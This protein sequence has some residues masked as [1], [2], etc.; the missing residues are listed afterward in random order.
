MLYAANGIPLLGFGT[1]PLSGD[2]AERCILMAIEVGYR[3]FD[4]AQMYG[5]ENRIGRALRVSGVRREDLYIVTKVDPG[6]LGAER[7][8]PS[9]E[10]S[11]ADL[12]GPADLLLIHWPP[13]A[14][15]VDATVD[16]LVA[17]HHAGLARA[18]G[19]SNFT[20]PLMRQA[21]ARSPV[22][23]IN[24]QVEFH[25]LIDQSKLLAEARRLNVTLSGYRPL[26]RGVLLQEPVIQ[27]IA[28]KLGQPAS[29]VVLRWIIQQGVAALPMTRK[30]EHAVSNFRALDFALGDD[31][32]AAISALN[33]RDR[34]MVS[35]SWM[36]A[37]W[38]R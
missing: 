8:R 37:S 2:E 7:F 9:V 13:P 25:P 26:G 16:R 20:V 33:R 14:A 23:L 28:G 12:G 29:A 36:T 35:P 34:R 19:V 11:I 18:I 31:D 32:M 6:N 22:P 21:V 1:Y 24:N 4:T 5:N 17:A 27:E 30:R 15:E 3:H 38:D 10:R